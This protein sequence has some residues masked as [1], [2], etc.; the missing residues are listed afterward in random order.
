MAEAGRER[1]LKLGVPDREA[2]EALIEAAGGQRALPVLQINHF[3][4]TADGALASHSIGL[5]IRLEGD[6]HILT[7]KGPTEH[8]TDGF[9]SDRVE[10]EL[11]VA[12]D[13]ALAAIDE[14]LPVT[15]LLEN[16]GERTDDELRLAD[17]VRR[18]CAE[19]PARHI[20]AF[21]NERTRVAS[22][23]AGAPVVL[24]FDRTHFSDAEEHFEVELEL[25]SGQA[26]EPVA[27]ALQR[28]F[29][30]AGIQPI[31]TQSKLARFLEIKSRAG[32]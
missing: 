19:T 9:L 12:G 10:L 17:S 30:R 28:L 1:E 20:G 25:S 21:R 13:R 7:V 11:S 26:A 2:L 16:L 8:A 22:E 4:D 18:I 14:K 5:R 6:L 27:E 32:T 24:E 15:A 3:F 29:E 31:P 23:L